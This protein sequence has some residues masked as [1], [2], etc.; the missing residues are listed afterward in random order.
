MLVAIA[1]H[2]DGSS[3]RTLRLSSRRFAHAAFPILFRS[4]YLLNTSE[5][6][7]EFELLVHSPYRSLGAIKQLTIYYGEWPDLDYQSRWRNNI[8]WLGDRG[9]SQCKEEDR[10]FTRYK[11]FMKEERLRRANPEAQLLRIFKSL[12]SLRS[13][14]ISHLNS[15]SWKPL[16]GHHLKKLKEKI[17]ML[18]RWENSITKPVLDILPIIEAYPHINHLEMNGTLTAEHRG[19]GKY[20]SVVSLKIDSLVSQYTAKEQ[21]RELVTAFPN[22]RTVSLRLSQAPASGLEDQELRLKRVYW[23][24]LNSF[25]VHGLWISEDD[26]WEFIE[27]HDR[28]VYVGLLRVTLTKGSWESFFTRMRALNHGPRVGDNIELHVSGSVGCIM[29]ADLLNH[30]LSRPDFPWPYLNHDRP[31]MMFSLELD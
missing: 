10:A 28:L 4:V 6:I 14:T 12:P 26:L 7:D 30:F 1:S 23:P 29:N 3:L 2:L 13:I 8:L 24:W 5:C 22:L 20:L 16:G 31:R 15:W 17:W 19:S 27:R 21:T 18:P 25:S 11:E 9:Q